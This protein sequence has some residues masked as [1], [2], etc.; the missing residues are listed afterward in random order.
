MDKKM[1]KSVSIVMVDSKM[2]LRREATQLLYYFAF[3]YN[4]HKAK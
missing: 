3:V 1:C 2:H 4:L